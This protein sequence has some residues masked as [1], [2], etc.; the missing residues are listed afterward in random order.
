VD[1]SRNVPL[2]ENGAGNTQMQEKFLEM[3][4]IRLPFGL[5]HIPAV[6]GWDKRGV[7]WWFGQAI[8]SV[9]TTALH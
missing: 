7:G 6:H 5:L 3:P 4:E 8:R 9:A 1:E 2:F